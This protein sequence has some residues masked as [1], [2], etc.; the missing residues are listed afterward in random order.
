LVTWLTAQRPASDR[1]SELAP[2]KSVVAVVVG[3]G[4]FLLLLV[5]ARAS[6]IWIACLEHGRRIGRGTA[7]V[8]LGLGFAAQALWLGALDWEAVTLVL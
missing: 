4:M 6:S 2:V 1:V 5:I 3:S 8:I 7:P